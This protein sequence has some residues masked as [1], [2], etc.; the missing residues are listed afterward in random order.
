MRRK[1]TTNNISTTTI[2]NRDVTDFFNTDYKEW[3]KSVVEERAL[4]SVIDGFKPTARKVVHAALTGSLKDGKLYKLLALSGD[5]MKLSLYSHGDM[6][7]NSVIVNLCKEFNDNLNPLESD[8]Q[9]GTLRDPDSAGSPRYLYVKH[10]KWIDIIYKTD[11]NLLNFVF[12]E[13]QYVEPEHYLPI[14]PTVLCK[15]NIGVA[16]GYAMHNISY[17]PVDVTNACIEYLKTDKISKTIIYPYI[18]GIDNENAWEHDTD[19]DGNP[20]W[21]CKGEFDCNEVKDKMTVTALPYDVTFDSFEKLLT[22]FEETGFIKSWTNL[23]EGENIKYE[24]TFSKGQLKKLTKTPDAADKLVQKFKLVK[25]VPTDLLWMLDENKKLVYFD[26]IY[27]IIKYFC[28]YRLSIYK[29]RKRRTVKALEEK[30]SSNSDM[31]Q[32]IKNIINGTL[33][34]SNR[35]K[36]D[37]KKDMDKLSLPITLLSTPMAKLT[38]EEVAA[39]EKENDNI[40]KELEYIKATPEKDMY[41]DDLNKLKKEISKLF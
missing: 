12:E 34:I 7:L 5:S 32:F 36:A 13:G 37:I 40:K 1:A 6:S 39:L 3:A 11:Y 9:V 2:I 4:P 24:I 21:V 20:V 27:A 29:E 28:S 23:S 19:K 31:C 33:K 14:I 41:L 38:K 26:G 15:N 35:S 25:V 18:K 10:S 30:Y 22:K 8:S 16:V 17:S